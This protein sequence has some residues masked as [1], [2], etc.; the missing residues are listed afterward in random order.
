MAQAQAQSSSLPRERY[1]NIKAT[2]DKYNGASDDRDLLGFLLEYGSFTAGAKEKERCCTLPLYM[3]SPRSLI[4]GVQ[5]AVKGYTNETYDQF[6]VLVLRL[7]AH[8]DPYDYYIQ[9]FDTFCKYRR[10]DDSALYTLF[11]TLRNYRDIIA[12]FTIDRPGLEPI[13]EHRFISKYLEKLQQF[14]PKVQ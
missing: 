13:S 5:D 4:E 11:Y 2:I 7:A 10:N 3:V 12:L 1:H 14:E 8:G 6:K 9:L